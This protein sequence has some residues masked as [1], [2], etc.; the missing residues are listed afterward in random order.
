MGVQ[1]KKKNLKTSRGREKGL[2]IVCKKTK[3]QTILSQT[4]AVPGEVERETHQKPFHNIIMRNKW[5]KTRD[6]RRRRRKKSDGG[7]WNP[8]KWPDGRSVKCLR[9]GE[10]RFTVGDRST[11]FLLLS[12]SYFC[13]PLH[14]PP[15]SMW[16]CGCKRRIEVTCLPLFLSLSIHSLFSSLSVV[17][18]ISFSVLSFYFLT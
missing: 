18:H 7:I 5:M 15:H 8:T 1:N 9:R 6:K 14:P 4:K 11:F 2:T 12:Y 3:N 13:S 10:N 16:F 17:I